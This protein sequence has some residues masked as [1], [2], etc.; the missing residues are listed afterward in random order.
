MVEWNF[1]IFMQ[2]STE[3]YLF[4]AHIFICVKYIIAKSAGVARWGGI[5]SSLLDVV[6][7]VL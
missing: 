4:G 2:S 7:N 6:D 3:A 1:V 5:D